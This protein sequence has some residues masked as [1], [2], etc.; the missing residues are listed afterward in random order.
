MT[1]GTGRRRARQSWT[2]G[3]T[4]RNRLASLGQASD[5][6]PTM[7]EIFPPGWWRVDARV[8]RTWRGALRV[9]LCLGCGAGSSFAAG[10][11]PEVKE[12]AV[13]LP[14]FEVL[15]GR[16]LPP[17]ESWR[18]AE[19]PGIEILTNASDDATGR[20]IR[21]F[22]MFKLALTLIWRADA[23]EP[24]PTRLVICGRDRKFDTLVPIEEAT[25]STARISVFMRDEEQAAIVLDM[26]TT[27]IHL[28]DLGN[29]TGLSGGEGLIEV[30]GA[31]TAAP[32]SAGDRGIASF[33]ADPYRQLYREYVHYLMSRSRQRPPAWLEEGLSQIVMA[34]RFDRTTIEFGKVADL[35]IVGAAASFST[36]NAAADAALE[37]NSGGAPAGGGLDAPVED[38]DFNAALRNRALIPWPR[39][40]AVQHNDSVA[41]NPLG[42]NLWAKQAYAFVHMCLYGLNKKYQKPFLTFVERSGREPVSEAM[43]EA[44]FG[45]NFR[46]MEQV[47]RN[48]IR[49]T[50]HKSERFKVRGEGMPEPPPLALRDASPAEIGRIK[51]ETMKLAGRDDQARLELIAPYKRGELDGDLLGALALEES[52]AGHTDAARPLLEAA[53]YRK[54]RRPRVYLE[55]AAIHL[56]AAKKHP[57]GEGGRLSRV[58]T[59]AVLRLLFSARERPPALP[60]VYA[61]IAETWAASEAA[62]KRA[63]LEVLDDGVRQFPR[64]IPLIS[65]AAELNARHGFAAAAAALATHGLKLP[66]DAVTRARFEELRAAAPDPAP[67]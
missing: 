62:P 10:D 43:F 45:K 11:Q 38:R 19:R 47:L 6:L 35:D 58:Q 61:L 51:A 9:A 60:A 27:E 52:A 3:K 32:A 56:A 53:V 39:F 48:Y 15:E 59:A 33:A 17:P 40:F 18:Y 29:G 34:M 36:G 12:P 30:A 41:L 21:R 22:E 24:V 44:C 54:A 1:R 28:L 8:R 66:L 37:A 2:S 4:C 20:L 31:R 23:A 67:P 65:S 7:S 63:N 64:D 50:D 57:E 46:G 26:Q 25:P 55:L 14:E 13:V 5:I 49:A 16:M 42:N